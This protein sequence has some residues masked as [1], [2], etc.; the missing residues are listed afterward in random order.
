MSRPA[1]RNYDRNA[2]REMH[3]RRNP[4]LVHRFAC[5]ILVNSSAFGRGRARIR[6]YVCGGPYERYFSL[7][8][9]PPA[10][11]V[12]HH[13]TQCE[14]FEPTRTPSIRPFS[15]SRAGP[16]ST[17]WAM[18]RSPTGA[19]R[20]GGLPPFR[21]RSLGSGRR[22]RG[23]VPA[24]PGPHNL[25]R[26]WA[27][28]GPCESPSMFHPRLF[29]STGGTS[30]AARG[31]KPTGSQSPPFQPPHLP[32]H[33]RPSP[34]GG[35]YGHYRT[36]VRKAWAVS[37][38]RARAFSAPAINGTLLG[39]PGNGSGVG[40]RRCPPTRAL[41]ARTLARF[42]CSPT[43]SARDPTSNPAAGPSPRPLAAGKQRTRRGRRS[44]AR[45]P[46]GLRFIVMCLANTP[47][48]DPIAPLSSIRPRVPP[49]DG[50]DP[51]SQRTRV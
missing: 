50:I 33:A 34:G 16:S 36:V 6:P 23:A 20:D 40:R 7:R 30:A 31:P 19:S 12:S 28:A 21:P 47:P 26:V 25:A 8:R 46:L 10:I 17:G 49:Y 1:A 44:R 2:G 5:P 38:L 11:P 39:R 37:G 9:S 42:R 4:C 43:R 22:L 48:S 35:R 15:A 29:G 14:R 18:D 27:P 24:S 13:L 3:K 32:I 51:L 41:A 45:E